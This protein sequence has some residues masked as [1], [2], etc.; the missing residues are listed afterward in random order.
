MVDFEQVQA[1]PEWQTAY[2]SQGR[3]DCEHLQNLCLS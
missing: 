3:R 2:N 1:G